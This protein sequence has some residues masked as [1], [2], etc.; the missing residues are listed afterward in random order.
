[1]E[2]FI[3]VRQFKHQ[4]PYSTSSC[5][6][7]ARSQLDKVVTADPGIQKAQQFAERSGS[8][9]FKRARSEPIFVR[10][11]NVGFGENC[12]TA[13]VSSFKQRIQ[14]CPIILLPLYFWLVAIVN[15]AQAEGV[16]LEA[17]L[18]DTAPK[19]ISAY[20]LFQDP[21]TM[22]P[23]EGVMAYEMNTALFTDYAIKRRFVFIPEGTQI[24][25]DATESFVFPVGTVLVKSFGLPEDARDPASPIRFVETRLLIHK[26]TGWDA[27]PYVWAED[28][29]DATLK[30]AGKRFEIDFVHDDGTTKHVRYAVPNKNQC[31]GCH[32]LNGEFTPLGP[33]ARNLNRD[34]A[35]GDERKNQLD[36]WSELGLLSSAPHSDDMPRAAIWDDPESGSLDARARAY[37]DV[38]CGHC[39]R[40]GGP[41]DN[42]GLFLD[43]LQT[44]ALGLGINKRPVA[45]GP[46]SGGFEFAILPGASARSILPFRM[47]SLDPGIMMPELG[48]SLVH[49]EGLALI[50]EWIDLM[51]T[52][53]PS[54]D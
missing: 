40:V 52:Q 34:I 9:I 25:Y 30:V 1:M 23:N 7:R 36:Q 12:N 18:A 26:A 42:S 24:T 29:S 48:R 53:E 32:S 49:E 45:A 22:T 51:E 4:R 38:N 20:N 35:Y 43:T 14:S 33:K 54:N 2:I 27:L 16:N 19:Q 17:V 15:A 13:L 41:A 47:E 10:D 11:D 44:E 21:A 8:R 3:N 31:K 50:R 37:L 28:M 46:G 39:H 6:P 5:H